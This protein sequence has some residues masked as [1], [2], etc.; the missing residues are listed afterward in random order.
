MNSFF[1]FSFPPRSRGNGVNL[2]Q[3]HNIGSILGHIFLWIWLTHL[4]QIVSTDEKI[5]TTAEMAKS[6]D[7]EVAN[8]C[9]R[10]CGIDHFLGESAIFVTFSRLSFVFDFDKVFR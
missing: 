3:A 5:I 9:G 10:F 1:P 6:G 7:F 2:N 4:T 8:S